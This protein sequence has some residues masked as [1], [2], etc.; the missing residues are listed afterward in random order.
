MLAALD[1]P[2]APISAPS[3]SWA[4]IGRQALL[5]ALRGL[6]GGSAAGAAATAVGLAPPVPV[7]DPAAAAKART[8]TIMIAAGVVGVVVVGALVLRRRGRR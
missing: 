6:T 2:T 8:R 5:D 1:T 4:D 3:A 7:V